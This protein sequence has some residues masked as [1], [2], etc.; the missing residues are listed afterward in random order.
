[1]R[2]TAFALFAF[3]I[4]L[5]AQAQRHENNAHREPGKAL[6]PVAAKEDDEQDELRCKGKR[7]KDL[8]G[9]EMKI[10]MHFLPCLGR[11]MQ[12]AHATFFS[13]TG[14]YATTI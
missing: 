5:A 10:Q 3:T 14:L 6:D 2:I 7:P 13:L 4:P 8:D 1:M 9:S 11:A 12:A